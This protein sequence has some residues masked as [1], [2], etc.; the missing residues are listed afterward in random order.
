M[1]I[2]SEQAIIYVMLM[3]EYKFAMDATGASGYTGDNFTL[4]I[5]G[6]ANLRTEGSN[7]GL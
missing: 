7:H 4:P 3:E 6:H 1:L 5:V 2:C